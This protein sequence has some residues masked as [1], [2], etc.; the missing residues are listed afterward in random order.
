MV[1]IV[2]SVSGGVQPYTYYPPVDPT[3]L[4]YDV[5]VPHCTTGQGAEIVTSADGQSAQA[6]W[7]YDDVACPAH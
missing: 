7:L 1:R 6:T 3:K 4:Y 5:T 2:V